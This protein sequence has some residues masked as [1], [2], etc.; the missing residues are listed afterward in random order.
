MKIKYEESLTIIRKLKAEI[1]QYQY[2]IGGA[3]EWKS[4]YD[5]LESK[6]KNLC[7]ELER[8]EIELKRAQDKAPAGPTQQDIDKLKQSLTITIR[9]ELEITLRK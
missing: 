7:S 1:E 2:N 3:N 8:L 5:L 6:Y 9:Q 4:K